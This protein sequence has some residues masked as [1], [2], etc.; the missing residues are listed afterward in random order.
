MLGSI[1]IIKHYNN[2]YIRHHRLK[3]IDEI[4]NNPCFT[5]TTWVALVT[6]TPFILLTLN[7]QI[8]NI[9]YPFLVYVSLWS[10]IGIIFTSDAHRLSHMMI[11]YPDKKDWKIFGSYDTVRT[12]QQ[13]HVILSPEFHSKHHATPGDEDHMSIFCGWVDVLFPSY[14]KI[15]IKKSKEMLQLYSFVMV[16]TLMIIGISGFTGEIA[17]YAYFGGLWMSPILAVYLNLKKSEEKNKDERLFI[18]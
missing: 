14:T 18:S 3:E 16:M 10:T 13:A 6:I 7:T 12:L 15:V 17:N 1:P 5:N 4:L 11:K 9:T 2:F 8:E